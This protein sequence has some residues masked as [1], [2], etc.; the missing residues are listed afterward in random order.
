MGGFPRDIYFLGGN[1]GAWGAE[2]HGGPTPGQRHSTAARHSALSSP[3][4]SPI[5]PKQQQVYEGK[6]AAADAAAPQNWS[7]SWAKQGQRGGGGAD[8]A[9]KAF[10]EQGARVQRR[11]WCAA[12][13]RKGGAEAA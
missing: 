9:G 4:K 11:I 8:A 6:D 2:R 3:S 5:P 12:A 1:G 7:S 10:Q 13:G